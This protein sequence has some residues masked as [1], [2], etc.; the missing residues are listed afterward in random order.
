MGSCLRSDSFHNAG[1]TGYSDQLSVSDE[2]VPVFETIT[3]EI[4]QRKVS[5]RALVVGITGIDLS[6]KTEFARSLGAYLVASKYKVAIIHLDD[7]HNP[8]AFR[9][10]GP[11]PVE[12][13][14]ERNFD[15]E[16]IVQ[17]LLIRLQQRSC[18]SLDLTLLDLHSDRYE[19][20]KR[21]AFD[22]DMIVLFEGIFLFRKE[23]AP[24]LDYKIFIE[25][26][27]EESR[28]RAL[29]R[30]VP[31]YSEVILHRYAEK[32]WPAQMKYLSEYPP[33]E[34]ADII[35]DNNDWEHPIIKFRR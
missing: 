33:S 10:S 30:D 15:I 27:R 11:D 8:R 24:Y 14:L 2:K 13:Y 22:L 26:D 6:G 34:I 7:F 9:N 18:F 19:I 21:F 1:L 4:S 5:S 25:I 32:Y 23:L 20:H 28:R 12:N 3:Q 29:I 16:S 35:I 17:N 31:V